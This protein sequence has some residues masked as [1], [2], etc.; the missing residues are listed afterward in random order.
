MVTIADGR[1][2]L[3]NELYY[4]KNQH[5]YMNLQKKIIG[6]DQI[7]YAFLKN[8]T[9]ISLLVENEIKVGLPFV[10]I[11]SE[12]GVTT[13]NAP[14]SGKI[15]TFNEKALENMEYDTYVNGFILKLTEMSDIS[16]TLITGENIESWAINEAK[17]L[18]RSNYSFKIIEIGDTAVGKTAIKVRF[19]DNYFKKD[20]KTTLGVDF[21]TK[22]IKTSYLSTD[23]LF[24]GTYRFTARMNVWDA[25]GQDQYDKIRGIYF[26]DAK[27]ALICYDI[28]NALSFK[29]LDKWVADLEENLGKVPVLLV[30][31][32][33]D[34]ERKVSR[35]EGLNY[36][37]EHGFL[38]IE[39]SA[40][41][42]ENVDE[43]FEKLAI[44][45]FKKEENL[46]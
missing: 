32:K 5:V 40:K 18:L 20:L 6:L 1:Y 35:Q 14:C 11:A 21:G 8:P 7:G 38:F 26:K 29:H 33:S 31:N 23:L 15:E 44:E 46:E 17:T 19:T 37:I 4:S 25:A 22:E 2:D 34:L 43:M 24:S 30:G 9:E 16:P 12:Q 36:A 13:L 45:I 3:P 28:N 41:T 39:C 27:G 42:G 10:A